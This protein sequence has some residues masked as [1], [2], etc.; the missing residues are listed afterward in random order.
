[1]RNVW[2]GF[3]IA[4][5]LCLGSCEEAQKQT[6]GVPER[7]QRQGIAVR[8][9]TLENQ[10]L[11]KE[12][13]RLKTEL[14]GLQKLTRAQKEDIQKILSER[15][16]LAEEKN[17]SAQR[18]KGLLKEK[19]GQALALQSSTQTGDRLSRENERLRKEVDRLRKDI[20]QAKKEEPG[21]KAPNPP[22]SPTPQ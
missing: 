18:I 5:L 2:C 16:K 6:V 17:A 7:L 13:R 4:A 11:D 10:R 22:Q 8:D 20:E 19:E 15:G 9:T 12:V 14:E 3:G 21:K 1:M